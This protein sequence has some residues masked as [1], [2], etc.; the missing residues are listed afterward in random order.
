MKI[1]FF[2]TGVA[3]PDDRAQSGIF[4]ETDVKILVDCG[5]G[6]LL[7]MSEYGINPDDID[8][9][10]ITHSHTDH[11][12]DLMAILKARWLSGAGVLKI[13]APSEVKETFFTL[14]DAYNYLDG[15]LNFEFIDSPAV[16]DDTEIY[17]TPA[18]HSVETWAYRINHGGSY[19]TISGDTHPVGRIFDLAG[20]GVLIHELS[21]PSGIDI[22]NHSTPE[23]LL[24]FIRKYKLPEVIFTHMYPEA[25]EKIDVIKEEFSGYN[26]DFA[27]DL[28]ELEV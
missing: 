10:L 15:K 21:F 8:L 9:M 25:R 19:L 23:K 24:P 6:V 17:H 16:I 3:I 20:H 2:G 27:R 18:D 4:V 22:M 5:H 26:V 12:G 1:V 7:R 11:M 13:I 14:V 28:M